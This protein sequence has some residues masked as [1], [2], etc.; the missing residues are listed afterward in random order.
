MVALASEIVRLVEPRA[1][2]KAS[3]ILRSYGVE[4]QA[5]TADSLDNL[6]LD[7]RPIGNTEYVETVLS[8]TDRP[9]VRTSVRGSTSAVHEIFDDGAEDPYALLST[10]LH[11][12]G[13]VGAIDF[14]H[15]HADFVP[16]VKTT[17]PDHRRATHEL[18]TDGAFDAC[19]RVDAQIHDGGRIGAVALDVE[20]AVDLTIRVGERMYQLVDG[21][22]VE[23]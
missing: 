20:P 5:L 4:I 8:P 21:R 7:I 15:Y 6:R 12:D 14:V 2:H 13:K 1:F 18:F 16:C 3:T 17:I 10:Q 9:A 11:D 22:L 19:V 23:L